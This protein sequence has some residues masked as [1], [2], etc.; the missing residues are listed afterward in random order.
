MTWRDEELK[1]F[2]IVVVAVI[3]A[4]VAITWRACSPRPAVATAEAPALDITPLLEPIQ[5]AGRMCQAAYERAQENARQLDTQR[6]QI[7]DLRCVLM[8]QAERV[9]KPVA[10]HAW[11]ADWPGFEQCASCNSGHRCNVAVTP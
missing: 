9:H 11:R 2:T 1:S 8:Y 6:A 7:D 3:V 4:I 5:E 10:T